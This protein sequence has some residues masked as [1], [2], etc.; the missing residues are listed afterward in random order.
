MEFN[1]EQQKAIEF[2][3]EGRNL[4]VTGSAGTGKSIVLEE[5]IR[6]LR[7]KRKKTTT[8]TTTRKE[9]KYF[10]VAVT[11]PTGIAASAF[12]GGSTLFHRFSVTPL[13]LKKFKRG[14]LIHPLRNEKAWKGLDTLV[15]DE[16]SMCDPHLFEYLDKQARQDLR[17]DSEPFGGVQVILVG[18]FFQLPPVLKDYKHG[19]RKFVFQTPVWSRLFDVQRGAVVILT[20]IYRQ[21]GDKEF[22]EI[23]NRMRTGT[24]SKQD[25]E[26]I[27]DLEKETAGN[28]D[29]NLTETTEH[30]Y[31]FSQNKPV[32]AMNRIRLERIEE[33][34][35]KFPVKI[36]VS[37]GE[38]NKRK[39]HNTTK[40]KKKQ[41]SAKE[42]TALVSLLPLSKE[43]SRTMQTEFKRGAQVM[44]VANLSVQDGLCNGARGIVV[45]FYNTSEKED[46]KT[47][48]KKK[49][50]N[51]FL[52]PV[53]LFENGVRVVIRYHVWELEY[54]PNRIATVRAIPLKLAYALTI[55]KAQGQS[56]RKLHINLFGCWGNGMVYVAFSRATSMK[57]GCLRVRR[58]NPK[59]VRAD[60]LVLDFYRQLNSSLLY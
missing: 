6:Q 15:I 9:E 25:V 23:L 60:S 13:I 34:L 53:V 26:K 38:N 29:R 28:V 46:E 56:I 19:D 33:P 12:N 37:G 30:T 57:E 24:L 21:Q 18:D 10:N 32:D 39:R 4:F 45:G 3:L 14:D 16:I 52:F 47:A 5:L 54:E 44:L 36:S 22:Q 58:F 8:N 51:S 42:T 17:C 2:A 49:T 40:K 35:H 11:A 48:K 43:C 31:L 20:R 41:L 59:D 27:R 7:S 50:E 55:H 1:F